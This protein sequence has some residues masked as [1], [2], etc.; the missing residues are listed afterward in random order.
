M[1]PTPVS[2]ERRVTLTR[3]LVSMAVPTALAL[4]LCVPATMAAAPSYAANTAGTPAVS[5]LAAGTLDADTNPSVDPEGA[6]ALTSDASTASTTPMPP[7]AS[8]NPDE[9]S[10]GS[11][12]ESADELSSTTMPVADDSG[13][14]NQADGTGGATGADS[15]DVA[16]S[17]QAVDSH[18]SPPDSGTSAEPASASP[19]AHTSSESATSTPPPAST[20]SVSTPPGVLAVRV[21]SS[22]LPEAETLQYGIVFTCRGTGEEV[23]GRD[24]I[25]PD[26]QVHV[27]A[28]G[29]EPGR[30][31]RVSWNLPVGDDPRPLSWVFD[32]DDDQEWVPTVAGPVPTVHHIHIKSRYGSGNFAVSKRLVGVTGDFS[33]HEFT[34]T[35]SCRPYGASE[36]LHTGQITLKGDGTPVLLPEAIRMRSYCSFVEEPDSATLPGHTLASPAKAFKELERDGQVVP[37]VLTNNYSTE[38]N[39]FQVSVTASG[40][41][42][43]ETATYHI[44]YTCNDGGTYWLTPTGDGTPRTADHALPVG[45]RCVLDTSGET[46]RIDG[47]GLNTFS[48]LTFTVEPGPRPM[49]FNFPF[50]YVK[51][52]K[53]LVIKH[54]V[55]GHPD[56]RSIPYTFT[57]ECD[58]GVTG[59][60]VITGQDFERTR[61]VFP[62]GTTCTVRQDTPT[63]HIP[64][65]TLIPPPPVTITTDG[66]EHAVVFESVYVPQGEETFGTFTVEKNLFGVTPWGKDFIYTYTCGAQTGKLTVPGNAPPT[67]SHV[68]VPVGTRCTVSEDPSSPTPPGYTIDTYGPEHFIVTAKNQVVAVSFWD[69]YTWNGTTPPPTP[70]T[71]EPPSTTPPATALPGTTTRPA[72]TTPQGAVVTKAGQQVTAQKLA[73]TG[74]HLELLS[75]TVAGVIAAGAALVALRKRQS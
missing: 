55:Y 31:C 71:T 16:S 53:Q 42:N 50:T 72:R 51:D 60:R 46:P 8:P 34:V 54:R 37:V 69:T 70:P 47:Y 44:S 65:Y 33:N 41:P 20:R 23:W 32:I 24:P 19:A 67:P 5:T 62:A 59:S 58:N 3:H 73:S 22:G 66:S 1:T 29:V 14:T 63:T 27:L 74:A 18:S 43:V 49:S 15:S 26:G 4:A 12:S 30:E 52:A 39:T 28:T 36:A 56:A 10:V 38:T 11:P 13:A 75:A 48:P 35:Y 6:P 64:G 17:P 21:T 25:S 9:T 61:H 2:K 45:S 68:R 7:G 40:A 57:Y